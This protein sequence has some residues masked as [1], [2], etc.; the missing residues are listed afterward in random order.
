MKQAQNL[1]DREFDIVNGHRVHGS[2]IGSGSGCDEFRNNKESEYNQIVEKL[3][4]H[5]EIS[6]Q[7]VFHCFTNGLQNKVSFPS[8]T[9]PIFI[10]N[11]EETKKDRGKT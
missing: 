11:L 2:V 6:P 9:T 1:F 4:K 3:L 10:K 5:P 7:N 8:R